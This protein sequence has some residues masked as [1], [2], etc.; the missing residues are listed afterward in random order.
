MMARH[1]LVQ[2]PSMVRGMW[3]LGKAMDSY[4]E[5]WQDI[6]ER[7]LPGGIEE[8]RKDMS[9][10]QAVNQCMIEFQELIP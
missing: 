10:A 5:K 1:L 8:Q 4:L 7:Y 3:N 2:V 9:C 6:F